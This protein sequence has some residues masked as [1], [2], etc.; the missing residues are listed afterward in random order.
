MADRDIVTIDKL[1][2]DNFEFWKF[3]M[4]LLFEK[5]DIKEVVAG[6]EVKPE[7]TDVAAHKSWRKKDSD[8]RYYIASTI[9]KRF[10][11]HILHTKTAKEMWEKICNLFE[12]KS[13]AQVT[14]LQ[15][16]LHNLKLGPDEEVSDYVTRARNLE[17]QLEST[18]DRGVSDAMLQTMIIG[19]LPS[20]KYSGFLFGWNCK[21]KADKTLLNLEAELVSAEELISTQDEEVTAMTASA[22]SKDKTHKKLTEKN[23][24]KFEGQCFYCK[25]AGHRKF[26]CSKFKSDKT[27]EEMKKTRISDKITKNKRAEKEDET[28]DAVLLACTSVAKTGEQTWL[29]DSGASYHMARDK[30]VFE[31]M[32]TPEMSYITLGDKSRI[33]VIGQ[34][35]V[36]VEACVNGKWKSC[37]LTNVLCVPDLRTNLFSFSQCTN[38]GYVIE[39]GKSDMKVTKNGTVYA[40]AVR[41]K[42]LYVMVFRNPVIAEA[43]AAEQKVD[44]LQLW[45]GRLGHAGL[46]TMQKLV[47]N[48]DTIGLNKEDLQKFKCEACILGKLKR[49]IFKAR[50]VKQYEPGKMVHS[51]V[52]GHFQTE[53]YNGAKYYVVFK[54]DASEYRCIYAIRSKADVLEKFVQYANAVRNRFKRE[55]KVL[56]TD[57]GREY[58]NESFKRLVRA[59]GIEHQTSAPYNPEQNGKSERDIQTIN[60]MIR[61]MIFGRH[62]P[63]YLW[64]EATNMAAY[65]LNRSVTS[66]SNK[67]PF[68]RW[69]GKKPDLSSVRVFGC[70]AYAHIPDHQRKKLDPRAKRMIFVGYQ[71][72]SGNYRVFD[73]ETRKVVVAASVEFD[74][75]G[76][77]CFSPKTVGVKTEARSFVRLEDDD[78]EDRSDQQTELVE[79]VSEDDT[80][81]EEAPQ[82]ETR[83]DSHN[84]ETRTLRD[85]TKIRKPKRLGYLQANIAEAEP[86]TYEETLYGSEAKQWKEAIQREL[87]AHQRNGTWFKSPKPENKKVVTCKWIFK[88]KVTP[89]E[90]DT[91]LGW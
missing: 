28:E 44:K 45:H 85:R 36:K 35:D 8:A 84:E 34:G 9:D 23:K 51:D 37:R 31:S 11:K 29:A 53:S 66:K 68:E 64:S 18:G 41:K 7:E 20:V 3:S 55:I 74:E 50:E 62:L 57:N 42:S 15:K 33:P 21:P 13:E 87:S 27:K 5:K 59:R 79:R 80:D 38:H 24:R 14:M 89:G 76:T 26:E 48:N 58:I 39:S 30:S 43:N 22:S 90:P 71:G 83:V 19:G 77:N 16:K 60:G 46:T 40:T 86:T 54:D 63:R 4:S 73:P 10:T 32:K 12:G 61:S 67:S 88:K 65:I 75:V 81:E 1:N 72:N 25:K 78:Y 56:K 49:K 82:P 6:T 17:A 69:T 2:D 52:C 70:I 47:E 91:R